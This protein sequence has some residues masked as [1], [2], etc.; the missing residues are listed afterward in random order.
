MSFTAVSLN[1]FST[2]LTTKDLAD[3]L[4]N[5]ILN[6]LPLV[7]GYEVQLSWEDLDSFT[8]SIESGK[9]NLPRTYHLLSDAAQMHILSLPSLSFHLD[10]ANKL[11]G[12]DLKKVASRL[13][14]LSAYLPHSH[15]VIH[16]D[17]ADYSIMKVLAEEIEE[18]R[19]LT[20]E[21]MDL[22]KRTHHKLSEIAE[23]LSS[24]H[25][26]GLTFD[27][28]HWVENNGINDELIQ[29]I[30]NYGDRIRALHISS[31][32]SNYPG[33]QIAEPTN[34]YLCSESGY[35]LNSFMQTMLPFI[36]SDT[37]FVMEGFVPPSCS[38]LL[39]QEILLIEVWSRMAGRQK[40]VSLAAKV[41]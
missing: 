1:S 3:Q 22:R 2:W 40:D 36:S 37:S 29:F 21:N 32:R 35:S 7:D 41:I 24:N 17:E 34:H 25:L 11:I 18:P 15:F 8:I 16:P 38:A 6:S 4:S 30:S 19:V 12:F 13:A 27:I 9:R 31:P 23:L 28:C 26:L 10:A 20:I 5:L 33:Y 14:L 39:T